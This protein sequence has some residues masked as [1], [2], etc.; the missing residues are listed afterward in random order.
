MPSGGGASARRAKSWLGVPIMPGDRSIGVISVQSTTRDGRFTDADARLLGT[1]AANVGVAVQ[2][3]RLYNEARRSARE[4]A[5]LAEVGREM[6]ARL[7]LSVVL[8]LIAERARNLLLSRGERG[9]P[10][11]R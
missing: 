7:E 8:E 2:N 9:L 6:S 11:R 1:I 4:M 3:A 5:A 10:A